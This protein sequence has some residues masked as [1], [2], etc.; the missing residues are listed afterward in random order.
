MGRGPAAGGDV[1]HGS[2]GP[3]A[4]RRRVRRQRAHRGGVPARRGARAPARGGQ[5]SSCSAPR[6]WS[7]SAARSPT[8]SPERPGR[9]G[10]SSSWRTRTRSSSRWT[11]ERTWFRYHQLFADLL[12]L[13]LRRSE[14]DAI[15]GSAPDRRRLARRAWARRR[16][17]PSRP[18]RRRL[19][20][21]WATARRP[22]SQ[23]LAQRSG[24]D[25]RRPARGLPRR[26]AVRIRSCACS[27]PMSS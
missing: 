8:S 13:E 12:R 7:G 18:G 22:R 4:V 27:S 19:E 25:H 10:S 26:C 21:R 23:P 2:P 24:G 15:G 11:P 6:S 14:P 16:R 1:A 17:D 9:S 20:A 5:A 3:R